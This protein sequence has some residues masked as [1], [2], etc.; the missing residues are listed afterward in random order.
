M[1]LKQI[2][3]DLNKLRTIA[4]NYMDFIDR[5]KSFPYRLIR[6]RKGYE[7]DSGIYLLLSVFLAKIIGESQYVIF[8][9]DHRTPK[10]YMDEYTRE[11]AVRES[12]YVISKDDEELLANEA[13]DYFAVN[14]ERVL[15]AY[16]LMN[17]FKDMF[18]GF[19]FDQYSSDA[20][21]LYLSKRESM[22]ELSVLNR[23]LR[24]LGK[25][26]I[27]DGP[28]SHDR[29]TLMAFIVQIGVVL[30][31]MAGIQSPAVSKFSEFLQMK[32]HVYDAIEYYANLKGKNATVTNCFWDIEN[33]MRMADARVSTI[34]LRS[35]EVNP[36]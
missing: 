30:K 27:A 7:S 35:L 33:Y 6:P 16:P 11:Q 3:S 20:Q 17:Q 21:F 12:Q 34:K 19:E 29:N 2:H 5:N 1:L 36:Q 25:N 24:C 8:S 15:E 22:L 9:I 4:I 10:G 13:D 18:E 23:V 26:I 31:F 32:Q 14:L 28:G